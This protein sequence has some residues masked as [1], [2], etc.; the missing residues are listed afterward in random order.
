MVLLLWKVCG[1]TFGVMFVFPLFWSYYYEF[2]IVYPVPHIKI[3]HLCKYT[4][5]CYRFRTPKSFNFVSVLSIQC[6]IKCT[7]IARGV[8]VESSEHMQIQRSHHGKISRWPYIVI[9]YFVSFWV[10]FPKGVIQ[11]I[12]AWRRLFSFSSVLEWH[13]LLRY[14]MTDNYLLK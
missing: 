5:K 2:T 1:E 3:I 10:I 12:S 4:S 9:Y 11:N 7:K 8:N 14:H 6:G 13:I